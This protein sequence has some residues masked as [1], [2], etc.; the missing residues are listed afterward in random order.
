MAAKIDRNIAHKYDEL[1]AL[2]AGR[3]FVRYRR[4]DYDR[5]AAEVGM[6]VDT[7][8]RRISSPEEMT[9]DEIRSISRPFDIHPDELRRVIPL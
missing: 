8:R 1:I 3:A 2:L 7:L 6:S 4:I 5:W 9:L